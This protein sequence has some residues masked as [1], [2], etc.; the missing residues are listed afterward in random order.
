M[1]DANTPEK[2]PKCGVPTNVWGCASGAGGKCENT[3]I[4]L[5]RISVVERPLAFSRTPDP[6]T[7]LKDV[8]VVELDPQPLPR[9]GNEHVKPGYGVDE[10]RVRVVMNEVV[11]GKWKPT[12][13]ARKFVP[14]TIL[15]LLDRLDVLRAE[16]AAVKA[17]LAE[18]KRQLAVACERDSAALDREK[19][20]ADAAEA[21]L[22]PLIAEAKRNEWHLSND[23]KVVRFLFWDSEPGIPIEAV[24]RLAA[25]GAPSPNSESAVDLNDPRR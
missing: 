7:G 21:R 14:D 9:A 11:D 5:G 20:R 16:L 22:A 13:V 19:Q 24:R 2:C 1:P 17:E 12:E 18:T 10:E 25:S 3:S 6:R 15:A 4:W 8:P 23:H